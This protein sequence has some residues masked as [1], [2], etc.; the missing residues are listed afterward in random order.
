[1]FRQ[2]SNYLIRLIFNKITFLVAG[3]LITSGAFAQ[4]IDSTNYVQP[5]SKASSFRT[6]SVAL[7]GG[8]I[9]PFNEDYFSASYKQPG[10]AITI[11]NQFLPTLGIQ[12]DILAGQAIGYN[13]RDNTLAQ[14]KTQFASAAISLNLTLANI[15]WRH[16]KSIIQPYITAGY[17]YMG[18]QPAITSAGAVGTQTTVLFKQPGNGV[19]QQFFVPVSAGFKINVSKGINVDLGYT[20]AFVNADDFDGNVYGTRNDEFSYIH[21]GLEFA[22][23]NHKKPQL[24]TH[25]PVN[26]MR[27]EYL[28]QERSLTLQI[29]AQKAQLEMLKSELA[30]KAALINS[31][32]ASLIKFTMDSDGDGVAD[33]FDKCPNTPVST[34]VDGAGCPLVLSGLPENKPLPK[35]GA[36]LLMSAPAPNQPQI[37][38]AVTEAEK[39]VITNAVENLQFDFGKSTVSLSSYK[40]LQDLAKLMVVKGISLKLSGYTDNV[41][42]D[43]VNLKISQDRADA[44]KRFLISRGV[45][46]AKIEAQGYGKE[47]PLVPNNTADGRL[48]NR[49]VEFSLF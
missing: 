26:S 42:P 48:L 10:A 15:N 27:I 49:R 3:I 17:G 46:P 18:Y 47:N 30:A 12:M 4:S 32:N 1:M 33:L 16:K 21:A 14:F 7:S 36:Q 37:K 35:A 40:T 44:V 9:V 24:S 41:G 43:A 8:I 25:N 28:S 22:I 11:K 29:N 13:S 38:V 20:V 45:N 19:I 5:F 34:V 2:R 39:R 23:G 6:W 31:T